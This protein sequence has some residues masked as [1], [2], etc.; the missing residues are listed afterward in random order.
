MGTFHLWGATELS[1][2][3]QFDKY[4]ILIIGAF[5]PMSA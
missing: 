2:L 1:M 5:T 3:D 4:T